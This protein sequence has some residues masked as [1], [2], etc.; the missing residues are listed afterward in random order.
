MHEETLKAEIVCFKVHIYMSQSKLW[1]DKLT[2]ILLKSGPIWD[3]F[4]KKLLL[5]VPF[6]HYHPNRVY[7]FDT[8]AIKYI[9]FI[10]GWTW[11]PWSTR[12]HRSRGSSSKYSWKLK[13]FW[14]NNH[15]PMN[16]LSFT[17]IL[18]TNV[19]KC[20][21]LHL[22]VRLKF[23]MYLWGSRNANRSWLSSE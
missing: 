3:I 16:Q 8:V 2:W 6:L 5:S 12:R 15:L 21:L 23:E 7:F 13:A 11:K 4:I 1:I 10:L 22:K 17:G 9:L 14:S 19:N 18:K 20:S